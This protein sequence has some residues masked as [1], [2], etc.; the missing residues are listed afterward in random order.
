MQS[1]EFIVKNRDNEHC[2]F[3]RS[4]D[5]PDGVVVDVNQIVSSLK[6][7]YQ[8]LNIIISVNFLNF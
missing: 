4:L 8:G 7:L 1:I 5:V 6:T 3:K 2:H